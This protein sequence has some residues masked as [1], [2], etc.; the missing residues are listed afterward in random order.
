M[1]TTV[2]IP[3]LLEDTYIFPDPLR[4]DKNGLLAWGGDLHP[5]RLLEAYAQGIFPWFSKND[6]LLWWSPDPRA[7]LYPYELKISKSFRQSIGKYEVRFNVDFAQ[8]MAT[9]KDMRADTW[10]DWR[11]QEA[12]LKLHEMGYAKSV[13][14]YLDGVL[15]GGLYGVMMGAVFC[16]E[17]MFS[18]E[19]DASKVALAKLCE[20]MVQAGGD[21]IDC[22]MPTDHLLS[23]GAIKIY[24]KD[25]IKKLSIS[26]DK[27][28]VF[29]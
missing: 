24:R 3:K 8:I 12:Y 22:Q 19:R 10:I 2:K 17:S 16:G 15:V 4:A 1:H 11:M 13:G 29:L 9:C 5:Q 18:K 20:M 7:I 27:K 23:L 28:V 26:R 14:T 25:F 21:F 6:P